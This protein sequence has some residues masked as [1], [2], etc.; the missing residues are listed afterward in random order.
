MSITQPVCLLVALGTQ[1][2]TRM[3]HIVICGLPP[4]YNIFPHYLIKG[5]IFQN[6]LFNIKCVLRVS[7]QCLSEIF[8]ILRRNERDIIE[9]IYTHTILVFM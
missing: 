3:R 6:K 5:T 2:A 4:P 9:Y 8:L 7:L 1:H